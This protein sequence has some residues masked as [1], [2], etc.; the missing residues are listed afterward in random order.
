[1][2]Y[3][4]ASAILVLMS[5]SPTTV[6]A[7]QAPRN[8]MHE[9]EHNLDHPPTLQEVLEVGGDP[10]FLDAAT[11]DYWTARQEVL[12]VGGDPSFLDD[13]AGTSSDALSIRGG[14]T[15]PSTWK[16]RGGPFGVRLTQSLMCGFSLARNTVE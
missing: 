9:T 16:G 5:F 14:G 12:N 10:S 13:A 6:H 11:S 1:M 7:V 2:L 8:P 4:V 15:D 3:A